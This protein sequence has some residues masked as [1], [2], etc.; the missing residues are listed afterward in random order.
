V[1]SRVRQSVP[2]TQRVAFRTA[3]EWVA[4]LADA[5]RAGRLD[6]ELARLQ[7][8]P[9]LIVDEVGYIPSIPR[10]RT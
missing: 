10:P 9:L 3:T 6:D 1:L 4:V 8:Y 5:Q 7:R 2:A